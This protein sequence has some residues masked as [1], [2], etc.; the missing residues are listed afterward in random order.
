MIR[1]GGDTEIISN[2]LGW[3]KAMSKNLAS[4]HKKQ[5]PHCLGIKIGLD[6]EDEFAT[7]VEEI[8]LYNNPRSLIMHD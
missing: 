8:M 7:A 4:M 1:C 3:R 5:G 2:V 6:L